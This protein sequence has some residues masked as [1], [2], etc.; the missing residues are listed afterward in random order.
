MSEP[1]DEDDQC[2]ECGAPNDDGAVMSHHGVS[3]ST[4]CACAHE[5]EGQTASGNPKITPARLHSTLTSPPM[6]FAVIAISR[7]PLSEK[8]TDIKTEPNK[9]RQRSRPRVAFIAG[10]AQRRGWPADLGLWANPSCQGLACPRKARA[11]PEP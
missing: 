1:K 3:L 5:S 4:H 2:T 7:T 8:E 11:R 9:A 10:A 6:A